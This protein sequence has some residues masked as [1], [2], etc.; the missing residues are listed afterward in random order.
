MISFTTAQLNAWILAFIFPAVRIL[1]LVA[2]APFL[3]NAAIPRRIRLLFGLAICVALIPGLPAMPNVTPDSGLGIA[4][5]AQQVLIGVAMGF[6]MRIVFAGVE[7]AGFLISSQ[8]G[9]GFATTYDPQSA[10]NTAVISEF[11]TLLATMVFLSLNGHLLY[12]ATL[13][14][15][16][17]AIPVVPEML[18][19]QSWLS[20]A[21][22]GS[23]IFATGVLLALP[24]VV[25]LM[26]TNLAL[27]VLNRVAQQ[28][29]LFAIGFPL[30]LTGGFIVLSITLNYMAAP[31]QAL[32][33]QGLEM[34]L[35]FA[36]G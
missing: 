14:Q 7:M 2:V 13:A 32:F 21:K 22:M 26:I 31:L 18:G 6:S 23:R 12:V 16:F 33:E 28:L 36:Q 24:A 3:S 29:N 35:G 20:L 34:M 19:G 8:M 25:A 4:I 9:L 27:G 30:T 10:S 15:S 1:A 5:L 17:V 11:L